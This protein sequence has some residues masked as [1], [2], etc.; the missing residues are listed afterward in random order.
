MAFIC[1]LVSG[2]QRPGE[3]APLNRPCDTRIRYIGAFTAFLSIKVV[4][5]P[6]RVLPEWYVRQSRNLTLARRSQCK[7]R[8]GHAFPRHQSNFLRGLAPTRQKW[9]PS[10]EEH[11][12]PQHTKQLR[13]FIEPV[14]TQE[15]SNA[16]APLVIDQRAA[17]A[18]D[19]LQHGSEFIDKHRL[20]MT[21]DSTPQ[22]TIGSPDPARMSRAI[23]ANTGANTKSAAELTATSIVRLSLK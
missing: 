13:Q 2:V 8:Q 6:R 1:T 10:D 11:A 16:R 18:I 9:P 12:T 4:K 17:V 23:N 21:A 22:N 3:P 15:S 14:S 19:R 5:C 7:S 20:T